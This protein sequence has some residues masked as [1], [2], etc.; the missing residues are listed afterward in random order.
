MSKFKTWL[1][2]FFEEVMQNYNL[3]FAV[4]NVF[5]I[6]NAPCEDKNH[7]FFHHLRWNS[8]IFLQEIHFLIFG[9]IIFDK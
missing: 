9:Q 1:V 5:I 8:G 3:N 4:K 2:I 7:I 6:L